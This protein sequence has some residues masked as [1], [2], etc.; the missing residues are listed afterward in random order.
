MATRLTWIFDL[1]NTLHD[2]RAR[3]M[4]HINRSMTEFV[5]RELGVPEEEAARLRQGLRMK[6]VWVSRKTRAPA[7]VDARVPSVL[8]LPR[9]VH[10]L[11]LRR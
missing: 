4:P 7:W 11:A 3:V 8:F 5:Q 1:D 10:N 9:L 6:T 2:A